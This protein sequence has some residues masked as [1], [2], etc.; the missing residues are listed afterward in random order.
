M[1]SLFLLPLF[2]LLG[3]AAHAQLPLQQTV[4]SVSP[5][6]DSPAALA[7]GHAAARGAHAQSRLGDLKL[8][9]HHASVLLSWQCPSSAD[10]EAV[11]CTIERA[12]KPGGWEPLAQFSLPAIGQGYSFW[13]TQVKAGHAYYYR[14]RSANSE[15]QTWWSSPGRVE[16]DHWWDEALYLVLLIAAIAWAGR[17]AVQVLRP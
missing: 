12:L 15:G 11:L 10:G 4:A 3:A 2:L 9:S 7:S 6:D 13:D 8:E 17:S 1:K 14:V 5:S 16:V